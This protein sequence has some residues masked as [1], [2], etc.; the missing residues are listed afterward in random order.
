MEPRGWPWQRLMVTVGNLVQ[1]LI[2]LVSSPIAAPGLPIYP[3][4]EWYFRGISKRLRGR[5]G[6]VKAGAM[7]GPPSD[8][9]I[10]T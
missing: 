6:R 10:L 2:F 9:G 5:P 3:S 8:H 7:H 1:F 4:S